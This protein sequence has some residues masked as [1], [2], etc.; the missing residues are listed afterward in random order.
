MHIHPAERLIFLI[1]GILSVANVALI[2]LKDIEF[3]FTGAEVMLATAAVFFGV[4]QAARRAGRFI[5]T[6]NVLLCSPC[7][8]ST[9]MSAPT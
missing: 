2:W 7:S 5:R 8:S 1:I 6:S 3:H 9:A 4:S